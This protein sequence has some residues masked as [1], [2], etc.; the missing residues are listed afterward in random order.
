MLNE[1]REKDHYLLG[2]TRDK[3]LSTKSYS[4]YAALNEKATQ[5]DQSFWSKIGVTIPVLCI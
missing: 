1:Y 4:I 2:S 5:I 3:G